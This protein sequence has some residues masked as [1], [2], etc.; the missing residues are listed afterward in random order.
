MKKRLLRRKILSRYDTLGDFAQVI[1]VTNTTLASWVNGGNIPATRITQIAE[2]L[3]ISQ[4]E[5]GEVFFPT[6]GKEGIYE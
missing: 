2:M 5:I 6:I 4:A 1:G 3:D